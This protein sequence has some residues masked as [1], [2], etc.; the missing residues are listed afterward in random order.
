MIIAAALDSVH[1]FKLLKVI[2]IVVVEDVV[3]D[4]LPEKAALIDDS[5]FFVGEQLAVWG[6]VLGIEAVLFVR[7]VVLL[8]LG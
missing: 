2:I 3:V 7:A 8:D 1:I 4:L 6:G 5:A